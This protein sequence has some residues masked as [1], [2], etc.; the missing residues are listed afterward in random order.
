MALTI[1]DPETDALAQRLAALTGEGVRDAVRISLEERLRRE[2][3]HRGKKASLERLK[4]IIE[5]YNRLPV[6]DP[7]EPDEILGYD[8]NG[9]PT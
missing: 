8:E 5:E 1:D 3:L 9:L 2:E 7:R 4:A 6:V